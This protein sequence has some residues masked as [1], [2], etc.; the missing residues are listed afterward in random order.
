VSIAV[1]S[2]EGEGVSPGGTATVDTRNKEN[3]RTPDT[4]GRV[5]SRG[6]CERSALGGTGLAVAVLAR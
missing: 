2:D 6:Y 5:L 3:A 1:M 4:A